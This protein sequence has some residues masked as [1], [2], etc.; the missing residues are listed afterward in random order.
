MTDEYHM[1]ILYKIDA[2]GQERSLDIWVEGDILHS[3]SG[4]CNGKKI[5]HSR[6]ITGTSLNDSFDHARLLAERKW[7]KSLKDYKPKCKEGIKKYESAL[8]E[9]NKS[10]GYNR[11]VSQTLTFSK[12]QAD[13]RKKITVRTEKNF[14]V[15][16]LGI[17]VPVI[18]P[19]KADTWEKTSL[20]TTLKHL[21]LANGAYVQYKLDGQRCVVRMIEGHVVMTTSNGKEYPWFK[22]IREEIEIMLEGKDYCDGLDGEIYASEFFDEEGNPVPMVNNFN[23]I[24]GACGVVRTCPSFYED[25]LKYHVFDLVDLSSTLTQTERFKKLNKLFKECDGLDRIVKVE[26]RVTQDITS[27]EKLTKKYVKNSYEGAIVRSKD[28]KYEVKKRSKFMRKIKYQNDSEFKVVGIEHDKGVGFE[29]FVWVCETEDGTKFNAKPI[30]TK[31]YKKPFYDNSETYI[32]KLL[33]VKY[34]DLGSNGVPRFPCA[35]GFRED[36]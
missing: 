11:T 3:F 12:K 2:K 30:G 13:G 4:L 6:T 8:V 16:P 22:K 31:A 18:I 15:S 23:V 26:T 35:K 10:G 5:L 7:I 33:T 19:M 29:H 21:N 20:Q 32:G 14:K 9:K 36:L 27:L 28:M 34:Q 1:P 24:Q 17:E 25:Q